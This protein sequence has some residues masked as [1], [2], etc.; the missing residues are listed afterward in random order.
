MR[1]MMLLQG[2]APVDSI[3]TYLAAHG[4]NVLGC[5]QLTD[6]G[7]TITE[8]GTTPAV[9][10]HEISVLRAVWTVDVASRDAAI[11]LAKNAPGE[12]A[13]LEV[14][15]AFVPQDFGA[16]PD[17]TP[18][19]P[20]P[21]PVRKP[22]THRYIAF[23]RSHDEDNNS[24]PKPASMDRMDA[25]CGPL[26]ESNTMIGGGGLKA[27]KKGTRVRRKGAQR[28]MVDGPFAESKE[29]VGGYMIVQVPTLD[30]AIETIRPW[31]TIHREGQAVSKS[32]IEVR[33]L[34]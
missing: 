18:P 9:V 33:R 23:I 2:D 14:R 3:S 6:E 16:P 29:L 34:V 13:T 20:P 19:A 26:A 8:V 28:F 25:Y 24:G 10:A 12:D 11:E 5:E 22:G 17:A 32:T 30:E 7:A 31:V 15:E 4:V 1:L 21:P 27:S